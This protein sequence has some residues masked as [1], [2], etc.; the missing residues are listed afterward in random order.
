M[1]L[2]Y[3]KRRHK[4]SFFIGLAGLATAASTGMHLVAAMRFRTHFRFAA[5]A[6]TAR[7]MRQLTARREELINRELKAIEH[8]AGILRI[9]CA[10][11]AVALGQAD[12]ISGH[13]KLDVALK[14][15]NAK[16]ADCNEQAP[17]VVPE[18]DIRIEHLADAGRHFVDFAAAATATLAVRLNDLRVQDNRVYDLDDCS[19]IVAPLL[20]LH[21]RTAADK[22]RREDTGSALAAK[23]YDAL[24]GNG[25]AIDNLRASNRA[26]SLYRHAI[27]EAYVNTVKASVKLYALDIDAN[28]E[29]LCTAGLYR[30][31]AVVNKLLG[32][33]GQVHAQ[34]ADALFAFAGIINLGR[35]HADRF[36]DAGVAINRP[37]GKFLSHVGYLHIVFE[38]L[39]QYQPMQSRAG[40]S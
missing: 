3:K 37:R 33:A 4:P 5:S 8:I 6:A 40:G 13:Q 19:R 28:A 21:I 7:M 14:A 39:L 36:P 23:E 38:D 12:V 26:G 18:H 34:V 1:I 25:Q 2:E 10:A 11:R 17:H 20:Q 9:V 31:R 32:V 16:L 29:Q 22:A 27:E 24:V 30:H 35:M 15:D